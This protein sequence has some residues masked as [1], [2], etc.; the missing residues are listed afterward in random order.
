MQEINN[1]QETSAIVSRNFYVDE[2]LASS[3]APENAFKLIN[4][5]SMLLSKG[6]MELRKKI[7]NCDGV[8]KNICVARDSETAVFTLGS[9]R[10]D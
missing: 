3:D 10:P 7:S 6:A 8:L 9:H 4:E 5:T 1:F 2:L